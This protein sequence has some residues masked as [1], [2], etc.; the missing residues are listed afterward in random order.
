MRTDALF[1][2]ASLA[3]PMTAAALMMLVDEGQMQLDD[4]VETYLP[5]FKGQWL[6]RPKRPVTVR[7]LLSHTSGLPFTS[8]L[9]APT[10]DRLPLRDAV[11]SYAMTPLQFEPGSHYRYSNAGFNTAGRLIEVVSGLP[12]EEFMRRRL[13]T[14]LG[15]TDTYFK[16]PESLDIRIAPTAITSTRGTLRGEVHDD[17]AAVLVGREATLDRVRTLLADRTLLHFAGHARSHAGALSAAPGRRCAAA[18]RPP[19]RSAPGRGAAARTRAL[20]AK[21]G[22][23]ESRPTP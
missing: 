20:P 21:R 1:W 13:F 12:Y 3:K 4:P 8:A 23:E 9:E 22:S 10:L 7:H 5:E 17:N 6:A 15:M 16:P 2:I 11:Q 19:R 14:P 18:A